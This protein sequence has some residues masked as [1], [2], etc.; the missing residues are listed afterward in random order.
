MASFLL[1][2]V[3]CPAWF[4][5]TGDP[6][7]VAYLYDTPEGQHDTQLRVSNSVCLVP[8][9]N[10][11]S[12][13]V[14]DASDA[15]RGAHMVVTVADEAGAYTPAQLQAIYNR[16]IAAYHNQR[17]VMTEAQGEQAVTEPMPVAAPATDQPT[18]QRLG[19]KSYEKWIKAGGPTS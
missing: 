19:F 14:A 12:W 7:R 17:R 2:G 11:D 4:G 1:D 10:G 13:T 15:A 16:L 6:L 3:M 8:A 18:W 5:L 9:D